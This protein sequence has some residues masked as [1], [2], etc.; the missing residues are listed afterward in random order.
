MV[1]NCLTSKNRANEKAKGVCS[2]K[3]EYEL[4]EHLRDANEVAESLGL[5]ETSKVTL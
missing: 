2:L 4:D 5:K 1:K 3:R